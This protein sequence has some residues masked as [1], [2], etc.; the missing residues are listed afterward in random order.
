[1][2]TDLEDVGAKVLYETLYCDRRRAAP[3]VVT[4]GGKGEC[5]QILP[6]P[7]AET[8]PPAERAVRPLP[9]SLISEPKRA[10][11]PLRELIRPGRQRSTDR[12][13]LAGRPEP[14]SKPGNE[15]TERR[16]AMNRAFCN[17]CG[18]LVPASHVERDG[19]IFL[20]KDCPTCGKTETAISSSADRYQA[21][22]SFDTPFA[23][24]AG[25]LRTHLRLVAAQDR[26]DAA[27]HGPLPSDRRQP[28][29]SRSVVIL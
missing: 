2:V 17:Q 14:R 27:D 28:A 16:G 6:F 29:G 22:R 25:R 3:A 21:K 20:A 12:I 13:A 15:I 11:R 7:A 26:N 4:N 23:Y 18:N 1:V 9:L 8:I 10:V 24:R 5:A 19:R